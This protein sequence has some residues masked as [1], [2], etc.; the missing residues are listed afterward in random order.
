MKDHGFYLCNCGIGI[1]KDG[2]IGSELL[3][4]ISPHT[5]ERPQHND[6]SRLLAM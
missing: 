6:Y 5:N 3:D 1:N 2:I 4:S